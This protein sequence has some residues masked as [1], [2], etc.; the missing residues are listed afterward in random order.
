MTSEYGFFFQK[1]NLKTNSKQKK[2]IEIEDNSQW[3]PSIN[4]RYYQLLLPLLR[5]I[6]T[7]LT[8]RKEKEETSWAEGSN[9]A[10]QVF[11]S[12]FSTNK[13]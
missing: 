1:Q 5:F 11:F 9:V 7:L 12:F 6:V 4:E 2:K 8:T 3:L 10:E 13:T